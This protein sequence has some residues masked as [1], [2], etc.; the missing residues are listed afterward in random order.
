MYYCRY[1][2]TADFLRLREQIIEIFPNENPDVYYIS[3]I[4]KHVSP[5]HTSERARGRLYERYRN[6]LKEHR[7]LE[8]S[9]D[10]LCKPKSLTLSEGFYNFILTN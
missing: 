9:N 4:S 7:K 8:K 3:P 10:K 5:L 6:V 1:L 2:K